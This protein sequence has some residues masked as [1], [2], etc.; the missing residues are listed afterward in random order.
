MILI[1]DSGATKTEWLVKQ[2]G[3]WKNPILTAGFNPW[4]HDSESLEQSV[5]T[6]KNQI[7]ST[8]IEK[9]IFYGAGCGTQVN[10]QKVLGILSKLLPSAEITVSH[11]LMA[12]AHALLGHKAGIACILG[13]GSN[14]C[15]FDGQEI[16][17]QITSLGYILGDEGS[18]TH[19]GKM[20]CSAFFRQQMPKELADK[21]A[22]TYPLQLPDFLTKVYRQA[23]AAAYLADFSRFAYANR[24]HAYIQSLVSA[25]FDLFIEYHI[26]CFK[27]DKKLP[28]GFTGSVAFYFQDELRQQLN[29]KGF[30]VGKFMKSPAQGLMDYYDRI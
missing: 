3:Q 19:I 18:G 12:S 17:A 26:V 4:Q 6:L 23:G 27:P 9:L 2:N 5:L 22:E 21:F 25:S 10:Q 24:S 14:A 7:D 28:I 30:T 8:E 15:R 16:T 1:A 20:L 13:T 29:N 11:D